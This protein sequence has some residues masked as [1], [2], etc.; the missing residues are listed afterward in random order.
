MGGDL[1]GSGR[2]LSEVLLGGTDRTELCQSRYWAVRTEPKCAGRNTGQY[3]Q[4]QNMPDE[5]LGGTDRPELCQT[6]YWVIQCVAT[7]CCRL[8]VSTDY[9]PVEG[10]RNR[11][12]HR[13]GITML[14][15]LLSLEFCLITSF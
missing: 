6:R 7:L 2:G 10:W 14:F 4:N 1:E 9:L 12:F 3:G 13:S 15:H 5:I 8:H 11:S